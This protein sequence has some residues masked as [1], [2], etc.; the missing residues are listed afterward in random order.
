MLQDCERP[1][2]AQ[3]ELDSEAREHV[4]TQQP[5]PARQRQRH[6]HGR[7]DSEAQPAR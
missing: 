4:E 7:Q 6:G 3:D 2:G 5:G 1:A